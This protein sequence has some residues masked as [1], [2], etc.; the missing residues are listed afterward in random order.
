[1]IGELLSY[2]DAKPDVTRWRQGRCLPYG[3]GIAFWALGEIVKAEAGILESDSAE[4]A[5]DKL[6]RIVSPDEPERPWLIERL[7]PL[8]GVE[9]PSPAERQ[10]LFTAWRRF[11]EGL[12]TT[13][14]T[15]L[16][17]EDLHWADQSLLAFLE[18]LAEWSQG[19]P[20]LIVCAAPAQAVRTPPRMGRP[21]SATPRRS[22]SRRCR[23]K[24][25]PSSS[26]T[27]RE[28]PSSDPRSAGRS[29]SAPRAI[30][31]T[32]RSSSAWSPTAGWNMRTDR[33]SPRCRTACTP[34]RGPTRHALAGPRRCCR[35]RR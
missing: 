18:Y 29:S 5:A 23:R 4:V 27:S 7:A 32:R 33:W 8:V 15:V 12:A 30:R 11:L 19:V 25:R 16:V 20:L 31:C 14:P 6:E 3:E 28:P 17:F 35:T 22:T 9:A 13:N 34:H 2:V 24:R 21:V 10:E 1:M 26:R